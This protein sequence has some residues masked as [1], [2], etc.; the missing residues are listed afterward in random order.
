LKYTGDDNKD[1][2]PVMLHRAILGSLERFIGVYLEHTNGRLPLWLAPEQVV[3]MSLNDSQL[4]QCKAFVDDL[5][6]EGFRARVD[7]RAEK[8]GFKIREAQLQRASYIIVIGDKEL[9]SDTVSVRLPNGEQ[10]NGAKRSEFL[11]IIREERAARTL[12]SPW[13]NS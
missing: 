13:M 5:K 1:H 11:Q 3:V 2:Q 7:E 6:R 8:L 9:A 4:P 10:K 12:K